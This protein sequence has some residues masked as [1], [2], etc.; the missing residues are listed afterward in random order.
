MSDNHLRGGTSIDCPDWGRGQRVRVL[1]WDESGRPAV[2]GCLGCE[3]FFQ[4]EDVGWR[5]NESA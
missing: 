1:V 4:A 3:Q 2:V 5:E